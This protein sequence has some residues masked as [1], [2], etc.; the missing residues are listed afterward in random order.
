MNA[1]VQV[2]VPKAVGKISTDSIMKTFYKKNVIYRFV[3][4]TCINRSSLFYFFAF[5]TRILYEMRLR[6]S[7]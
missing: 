7:K 3:L 1:V 5:Y 6:A 4:V 2:V